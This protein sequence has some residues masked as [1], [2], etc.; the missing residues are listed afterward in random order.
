M[1]SVGAGAMQP[2]TPA[3]A[4][5]ALLFC[6]AGATNVAAP[7]FAGVTAYG[8]ATGRAQGA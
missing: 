8:F 3:Q 5:A 7:A 6:D 1:N 4:G 2:V